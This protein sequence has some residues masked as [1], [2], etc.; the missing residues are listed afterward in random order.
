MQL[1]E[2]LQNAINFF[3]EQASPTALRKA[4][5]LASQSYHTNQ[6]APSC[7]QEEVLR[8]S[9]ILSRM[10]ATF[11]AV[12]EVLKKLETRPR[13]WLDLGAGFGSASWA[14]ATLF[15]EASQFVLLEKSLDA[16]DL[17]KRLAQDHPSLQKA[18]W[19]CTNLPC[20]L[21][22]ADAAILSYSLGELREAGAMIDQWWNSKI[23]LLAIIEPGTVRGFSLLRKTRDQVLRCGGVVLAPCPHAMACPIGLEDWCHFSTRIARTKLQRFVKSAS[24]G[25]EDEKFSYL[26]VAKERAVRAPCSRILRHPQKLSGHVRL[27]LCTHEGRHEEKVVGRSNQQLYRTARDAEWGDTIDLL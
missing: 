1:P 8:L 6:G 20:P 9:Y 5:E 23:P 25:Y 18:Q 7:F 13:I 15:P 11:S 3:V 16:I 21:P 12:C 4:R 2:E 27:T 22:E 14:A 19:I 26:I 10:P 24:L 17:G